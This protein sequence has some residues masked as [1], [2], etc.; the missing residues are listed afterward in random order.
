MAM[1]ATAHRVMTASVWGATLLRSQA[2]PLGPRRRVATK[3]D[4]EH[5]RS[6]RTRRRRIVIPMTR[7]LA[8]AAPA[9]VVLAS[10]GAAALR[11]TPT[12][13]PRRRPLPLLPRR[14]ISAA[15]WT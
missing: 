1:V 9:I 7:K 15:L 13:R 10:L 4:P 8:V 5:R 3:V 2:R 6:T 11:R 12:R 14:R